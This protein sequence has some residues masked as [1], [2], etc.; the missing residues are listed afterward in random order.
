MPFYFTRV[1][2]NYILRYFQKTPV[3][4]LT[5]GEC[6]QFIGDMVD[7]MDIKWG[8]QGDCE[9]EVNPKS[10]IHTYTKFPP[11]KT[12]TTRIGHWLRQYMLL[13]DIAEDERF[14]SNNIIDIIFENCCENT[15]Q[16]LFLSLDTEDQREFMN[17]IPRLSNILGYNDRENSQQ[18]AETHIVDPL[19]DVGVTPQIHDDDTDYSTDND[20]D[21][22]MPDLI[23]EDDEI[24]DGEIEDDEIDEDDIAFCTDVDAQTILDYINEANFDILLEIC[25]DINNGTESVSQLFNLLQREFDEDLY[26]YW[27]SIIRVCSAENYGNLDEGYIEDLIEMFR[28]SCTQV[29]AGPAPNTTNEH[30]ETSFDNIVFDLFDQDFQNLINHPNVTVFRGDQPIN[31]HSGW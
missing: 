14:H 20:T 26:E 10:N 9:C 16:K 27:D 25:F 29:L 6:S 13:D 1:Y 19:H 22:D 8:E 2:Q 18:Y 11:K 12:D 24:E 3:Q 7:W 23:S 17:D 15:I 21:D 4:S 5:L 30:T 28:G 31:I